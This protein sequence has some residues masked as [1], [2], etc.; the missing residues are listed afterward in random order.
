VAQVLRRRIG[1]QER[2]LSFENP[3]NRNEY[4]LHVARR[5]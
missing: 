1:T 3:L 2:F 5:V 4:L